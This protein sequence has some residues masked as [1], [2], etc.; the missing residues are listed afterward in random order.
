MINFHLRKYEF[1]VW[2]LRTS[3]FLYP[4]DTPRPP[5]P[6][7]LHKSYSSIELDVSISDSF[8]VTL[9]YEGIRLKIL[10]GG[11]SRV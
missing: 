6:R 4:T 8:D 7:L 11:R 3:R 5:L 2:D 10:F 9:I 1:F